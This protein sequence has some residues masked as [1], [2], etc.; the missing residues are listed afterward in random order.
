VGAAVWDARARASYQVLVE[1]YWDRRRGLFRVVTG[2]R[3]ALRDPWHY[4]WQAHALDCAVDAGDLELAARLVEGVTRRN[5]GALANHYYD[6]MA[7]LA[8][9][10]HRA[11]AAGLPGAA[12][13][14]SSLWAELRGG[15][16]PAGGMRWRRADTYLNVPSTAPTA[17]LAALRYRSGGDPDDLAVAVRAA[18][19]LATTLVDADSG[20]VWDGLHD[21][22]GAGANRDRYTYNHGSVA[23][24]L[25]E[26][27]ALTGDQAYRSLARRVALAA[28]PAAG[29]LPDEGGG[30]RGLF[31]GIYARYAAPLAVPGDELATGLLRNGESAWAARSPGGLFGTSWEHPPAG[32]VDLSA[33]LSGVLLARALADLL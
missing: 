1:R 26:L 5:G 15:W 22:P 4:W 11:A 7:W 3:A 14:E 31:K 29:A 27:A 2:W 21:R 33:H 32:N 19:W 24:L 10:L 20:A 18:G 30:D 9:A 13:L 6:D 12:A 17:L 28:L 23:G 25:G 8:L 16:H